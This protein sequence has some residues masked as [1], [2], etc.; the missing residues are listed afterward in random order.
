LALALLAAWLIDL[1]RSP[2]ALIVVALVAPAL[3]VPDLALPF[4]AGLALP[5]PSSIGP[6]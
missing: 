4:L 2:P 5:V 1:E 3:A 6:A